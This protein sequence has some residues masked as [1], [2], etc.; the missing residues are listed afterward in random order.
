MAIQADEDLRTRMRIE[1]DLKTE[2]ERKENMSFLCGEK[3]RN[4]GLSSIERTKTNEF[5]WMFWMIERLSR[6]LF[7]GG[8]TCRM[9]SAVAASDECSYSASLRE[10]EQEGKQEGEGDNGGGCERFKIRTSAEFRDIIAAS[11]SPHSAA[12]AEKVEAERERKR[13][14]Q[15]ERQRAVVV[16]AVLADIDPSHVIRP[17]FR[18]ATNTDLQGME[19]GDLGPTL[20]THNPA[21]SSSGTA[22]AVCAGE[23]QERGSVGS[24]CSAVDTHDGI[25]VTLFPRTNEDENNNGKDSEF[26]N[27]R[28]ESR[29]T[30]MSSEENVCFVSLERSLCAL[31]AVMSAVTRSD[32]TSDIIP[33]SLSSTLT[34]SF[35]SSSFCNADIQSY[36]YEKFL[37]NKSENHQF[38]EDQKLFN[39]FS[40]C[41]CAMLDIFIATFPYSFSGSTSPKE[42]RFYFLSILSQNKKTKFFL[43]RILRILRD[44]CRRNHWARVCYTHRFNPIISELILSFLEIIAIEKEKVVKE[45]VKELS[46]GQHVSSFSL[47]HSL[48]RLHLITPWFLVLSWHNRVTVLP[49]ELR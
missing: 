6:F 32:G 49:R 8:R 48:P 9:D 1:K 15:R 25:S 28:I 47:P 45:E 33:H 30:R 39:L 13:E 20:H 34:P 42:I 7:T 40:V 16:R 5:S 46:T 22:A 31:D 2:R 17:S 43:S 35:S 3:K 24:A 21:D 38:I 19:S 23:V 27:S 18:C 14:R 36:K 12:Q 41:V 29:V 26:Q 11:Q 37:E 10:R 4:Q 44:S